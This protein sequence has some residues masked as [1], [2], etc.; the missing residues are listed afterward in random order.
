MTSPGPRTYRRKGRWYPAGRLYDLAFGGI[1]RSVRRSVTAAA[2]T[3]GL[4]PWLDV[5]CGTGSQLRGLVRE[6]EGRPAIGLDL[7]PGM[8]RYAAARA[9]GR[10]FIRGDAA[11]LPFKAGVFRAVSVTLGLHD[12]DPETRAAMMDEA[13]RVMAQGGRLIAVDFET[14][15][16]PGSRIGAL[17]ARAIE[18]MAGDA[19]YRN[20]RD[21]LLRGGLGSFLR[22]NGFIEVSRRD[23]A[24]G[25]I[26][27]V[28]SRIDA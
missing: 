24:T 12:K 27:V 28:V 2:A 8:I 26:S 14:P 22:E 6:P 10:A 5:C 20:G 7:N 23:I 4:F 11:F 15:W 1:L 21:F 25:S 19:H 3:E 9:P 18:R 16:S 17:I 13:K